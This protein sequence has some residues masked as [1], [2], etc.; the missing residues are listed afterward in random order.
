MTLNELM[1]HLRPVYAINKHW[2]FRKKCRI[3]SDPV[4]HAVECRFRLTDPDNVQLEA[5]NS[6]IKE[7][8]LERANIIPF[9][10]SR[11]KK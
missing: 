9:P 8:G 1:K 10:S 4:V 3:G 11:R 2:D 6:I 5:L 7:F